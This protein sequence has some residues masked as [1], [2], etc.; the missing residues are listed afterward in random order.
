MQ[1]GAFSRFPCLNPGINSTDTFLRS[2][3]QNSIKSL[4]T[5]TG[6]E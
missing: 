5:I 2:P 3:L 4:A 6:P 1:E